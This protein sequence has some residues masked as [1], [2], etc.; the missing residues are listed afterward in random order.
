[1]LVTDL[2]QEK[3]GETM[4]RKKKKIIQWLGFYMNVAS[5]N[6]VVSKS[7]R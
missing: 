4:K 5:L 7:I 3:T 2:N 6:F 1:M